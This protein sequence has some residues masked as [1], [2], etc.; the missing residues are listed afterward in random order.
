[1][2]RRLPL[3]RIHL[4]SP[5]RPP[6]AWIGWVLGMGTSLSFVL[7]FTLRGWERRAGRQEASDL[8]L[9]AVEKLE[10]RLLRSLEVLNSIASLHAAQGR[11]GRDEFREF[12]RPAL[13]RQPE[14]HALSWNPWVPAAHRSELESAAV[15]EGLS[16]F[17]FRE[18]GG[19]ESFVPA[20][21]RAEYVPVYYIEPLVRNALALG[22]DL[23]SDPHRR[24]SLER[25]RDTGQPAATAP[26]RLAQEPGD[27]AGL[28]V[29][30]PIYRGPAPQDAAA[31]REQLEGF[32]VA[33][34]RV[35]DLVGGAFRELRARGIEA[36]LHDGSSIGEL[37]YDGGIPARTPEP[38]AAE[39]TLDFAGCTWTV[40]FA[41]TAEF[42]AGQSHLQSWLALSGGL[43][44][45]LLTAAHLYAGWRRTLEVAVANTALR[46]EVR[47]RQQAE[48]TA[49]AANA[50]KSDFLARMSHEIRTPLNAILG[51]AQF[52]QRA[53]RPP[54]DQ[55][56]AIE[57]IGASGR[58]LLGLLNEILDLSKIEAGRMELNPVDFQLV[59][60]A[61][62]LTVTFQPLCAQKQIGF[63][64]ELD[65]TRPG[66]VHGDEG[67]L[68]QILIN[69][70][71]NAVKFTR[72]GEVCLSIR[73]QPEGAWLFEVTDTGRGI[74]PE[75][76]TK[77]FEPFHQ[78]RGA[79]DLGGTGLGL[80]IAQRQVALLGGALQLQS[81][82]GIG[83]RF[84][85]IIPLKT[86][87]EIIAESPPLAPAES[88]GIGETGPRGMPCGTLSDG[89]RARLTLAAD[90]HSTT[91]LKA[92]LEELR[93]LGPDAQ[94]LAEH[95]RQR[96]RNYDMEGILRILAS[97]APT[98]ATVP[99]QPETR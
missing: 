92:G 22:Y 69:L 66:H 97:A 30:Q 65:R 61:H 26:L 75:E 14:L 33:V 24:G 15:A 1:M 98:G 91:A 52:L 56:D 58:H 45:T 29:L 87:T 74:P 49:A 13:A 25:A 70:L 99:T 60:L 78:G 79:L 76:Q 7:F 62:N 95:I 6:F 64:V 55:H 47:I 88:L 63:R 80:A 82:C 40:V 10:V 9:E 68:R 18:R 8:T 2:L 81:A 44:F 35:A 16:G 38:A 11:I 46:E 73:P 67:K 96:M 20:R 59:A 84:H 34:F 71:G 83:S 48:A 4:S 41:P 51:Y 57:G 37:M 43:A 17:Q 19:Q 3:A 27:Q 54:V 36:R 42:I 85:F 12:V 50:A 90:L 39:V 53:P 28:L 21:E 94:E 93:Q 77:V 31:R 86:A 5:S 72:T 23:N 32:A 89:L